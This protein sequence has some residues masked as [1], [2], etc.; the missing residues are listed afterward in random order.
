MEAGTATQQR[1]Q[2]Y[3]KCLFQP[4]FLRNSGGGSGLGIESVQGGGSSRIH[5][6]IRRSCLQSAA[7]RDK[8]AGGAWRGTDHGGQGSGICPGPGLLGEEGQVSPELSASSL[9]PPA[10]PF[11]AVPSPLVWA[12]AV[13]ELRRWQPWL[14]KE[15]AQRSQK[16]Q[17][18]TRKKDRSRSPMRAALESRQLPQRPDLYDISVVPLL[19][20]SPFT[21]HSV[22]TPPL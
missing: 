5:P 3:G 16:V 4:I 7:G 2:D 8:R 11:P 9:G 21:T 1:S 13:L 15:C 18:A 19:R 14:S 22:V 12:S 17:R 20:K 6:S 10:L